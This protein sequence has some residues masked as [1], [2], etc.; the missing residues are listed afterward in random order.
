M[1]IFAFSFSL[2]NINSLGAWGSFAYF[3]CLTEAV[4]VMILI[5]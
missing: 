4:L 3:L 5:P 1:G 2:A